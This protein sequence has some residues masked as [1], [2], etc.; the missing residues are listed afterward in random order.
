MM[1]LVLIIIE[2]FERG[3]ESHYRPSAT[4][5]AIRIDTS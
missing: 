1:L 4:A 3:C 2:V 5:V